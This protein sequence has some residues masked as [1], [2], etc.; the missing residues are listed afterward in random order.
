MALDEGYLSGTGSAVGILRLEVLSLCRECD[1][2]LSAL[3][4]VNVVCSHV[5]VQNQLS[6]LV[7]HLDLVLQYELYLVV[8][9]SVF[10]KHFDL[11][12]T[13]GGELDQGS[14]R[15]QIGQLARQVLL[16][17]IA[18]FFRNELRHNMLVDHLRLG[19]DYLDGGLSLL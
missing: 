15:V 8:V 6:R 16:D 5:Y 11:V 14:D 9:E 10:E 2:D 4:V 13:Y 1:F 17:L 18:L 7:P 19:H 12:L 3:D